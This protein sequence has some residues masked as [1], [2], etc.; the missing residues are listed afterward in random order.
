M[1]PQE[2]MVNN[3]YT[4]NLNRE[5][6]NIKTEL[7]NLHQKQWVRRTES[8]RTQNPECRNR[9]NERKTKGLIKE[10][11]KE[12]NE[13]KKIYIKKCNYAKKV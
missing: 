10:Y 1:Y 4:E 3:F 2:Y 11:E 5:W 13:T 6:Q 9:S 12:Y 8:E 7:S